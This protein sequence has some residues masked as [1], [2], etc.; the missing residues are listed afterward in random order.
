M[1]WRLFYCSLNSLQQTRW[2]SLPG[3]CD[4]DV[5]LEYL[6]QL[7]TVFYTTKVAKNQNKSN[8]NQAEW[9]VDGRTKKK[10]TT[11]KVGSI[12]KM[13]ASTREVKKFNNLL[14]N[15]FRGNATTSYG[16]EMETRQ[17]FHRKSTA[18]WNTW[19]VDMWLCWWL[20]YSIFW[21][22][23]NKILCMMHAW[24]LSEPV[25]KSTVCLEQRK[26]SADLIKKQTT[27]FKYNGNYTYCTER[28]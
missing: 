7:K 13:R 16:T 2:R 22:S 10:I 9:T 28:N 11:S 26:D 4:D 14:Y 15:S 18:G 27:N 1:N 12:A 21:F 5:F 20:Y 25:K 8:P 23:G 17:T 19:W 24:P 6:E 3:E